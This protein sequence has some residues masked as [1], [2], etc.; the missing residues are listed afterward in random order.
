MKGRRDVAS[1]V[2]GVHAGLDDLA[3]P[4]RRGDHDITRSEIESRWTDAFDM[5]GGARWLARMV[6]NA[7]DRRLRGRGGMCRVSVSRA[8]TGRNEKD[9]AEGDA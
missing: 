6:K 4:E 7:A 9:D 1:A 2:D 5:P 3:Q 8:Q